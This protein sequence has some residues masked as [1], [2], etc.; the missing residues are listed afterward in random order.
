[1]KTI[2][3]MIDFNRRWSVDMRSRD[4]RFFSKH[5]DGQ[6]PAVL[7]IG[8]SDSRVPIDTITGVA[9]GEMFVYRNIANQLHGA[10]LGAQAVLA[11]AVDTLGVQHILVMGHTGCGG[12]MAAIGDPQHGLVDHWLASVRLLALRYRDELEQIDAPEQRLDRLVTLNV[13]LQIYQLSLNPT[14][15]D[16]WRERRPLALHGMVYN[17]ETGLLQPVIRDVDSVEAARESLAVFRPA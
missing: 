7:S 15:R 16:A 3:D 1:M 10:D 14:V 5:A 6:R 8:C 9:P 12:V 17:I 13:E 11:F 2:D 4:P